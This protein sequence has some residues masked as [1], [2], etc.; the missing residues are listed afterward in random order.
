MERTRKVRVLAVVQ[1]DARQ[2]EVDEEERILARYG[3]D[4]SAA[5]EL[6][7]ELDVFLTGMLERGKDVRAVTPALA[8]EATIEVELAVADEVTDLDLARLRNRIE[9]RFGEL[10]AATADR[11]RLWTLACLSLSNDLLLLQQ[12]PL[13]ALA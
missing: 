9:E 7:C 6:L 13:A 10:G 4:E 12:Q 3:M 5:Q 1:D 8:G 11:A 2:V